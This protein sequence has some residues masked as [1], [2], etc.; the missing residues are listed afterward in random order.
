MW[1]Y[2]CAHLIPTLR[3][4]LQTPIFANVTLCFSITT[5][6]HLVRQGYR[7]S[8]L[9]FFPWDTLYLVHYSSSTYHQISF[10]AVAP[11]VSHRPLLLSPRGK[12]K[13]KKNRRR[14]CL[15]CVQQLFFPPTTTT[16]LSLVFPLRPVRHINRLLTCGL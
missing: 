16:F 12:E 10:F 6:T 2:M 5:H 8:V 7:M 9:G 13:K 1:Y 11:S 14:S 15:L 3:H 4:V